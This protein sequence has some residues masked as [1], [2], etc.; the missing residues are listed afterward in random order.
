MKRGR[1]SIQQAGGFIEAN[2]SDTL[3]N[4]QMKGDG[5]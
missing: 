5:A 3:V 4:I 2:G 1:D